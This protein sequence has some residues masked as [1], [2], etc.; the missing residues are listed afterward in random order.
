MADISKITLPSGDEYNFKDATARSEYVPKTG[1]TFSGAVTFSNS[2][3]YHSLT[4]PAILVGTGDPSTVVNQLQDGD[5][6]IQLQS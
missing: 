1:G 6:Y 3:T 4:M 5:I 2:V